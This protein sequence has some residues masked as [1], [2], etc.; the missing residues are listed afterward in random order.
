M[1]PLDKLAASP[2]LLSCCSFILTAL[3]LTSNRLGIV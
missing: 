1:S 3:L 2:W